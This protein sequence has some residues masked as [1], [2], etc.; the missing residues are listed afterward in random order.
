LQGLGER[1]LAAIVFTD[2]VNFS[3]R[4]GQSEDEALALIRRDLSMMAQLCGRFNGQVLK[5]TGDGL[6]LCFGSAVQAVSCAVEIQN[7]LKRKPTGPEL[8][9]Q[10]RISIHLGDVYIS[11]GDVLG[12]GVNVAARLQSEAPPGGICLSQT[13]YDVVKNRIAIKPVYQGLRSLK[14]IAE[15]VPV[16]HLQMGDEPPLTVASSAAGGEKQSWF[17]YALFGVALMFF[18]FALGYFLASGH[19][20]KNNR[21]ARTV[22]SAPAPSVEPESHTET[23]AA[24]APAQKPFPWA[25]FEQVRSQSRS[26]YA[27]SDIISWLKEHG[28]ENESSPV[29]STLQRY[30]KMSRTR[31][32]LEE[33]L[34]DYNAQAPLNVQN[35]TQQP[36]QK[37]Q[38]WSEHSG[39]VVIRKQNGDLEEADL[40][41]MSPAEVGLIMRTAMASSKEKG[42][43][44]NRDVFAGALAFR[45]EY[46]LG[47]QK[48]GASGLGNALRKRWWENR[49]KN[50]GP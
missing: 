41:S 9:L 47:P 7:T 38:L 31:D 37:W 42:E 16:Y 49:R 23:T 29:H 46:N 8:P 20:A 30:E 14:N 4:A 17:V 2:A 22:V 12:D 28:A 50:S 33:K 26:T 24:S 3:A 36:P 35:W 11:D 18:L 43:A 48:E 25:E 44:I 19:N 39:K 5:T 6:L 1:T 27:F 40:W 34:G 13:V 21:R 10:H 45:D 15:P 32:W